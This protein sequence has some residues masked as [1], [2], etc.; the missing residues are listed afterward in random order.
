MILHLLRMC[1]NVNRNVFNDRKNISATPSLEKQ[2]VMVMTSTTPLTILTTMMMTIWPNGDGDS[3]LDEPFAFQH[4]APVVVREFDQ[5]TRQVVVAVFGVLSRGRRQQQKHQW[6]SA[7]KHFLSGSQKRLRVPSLVWRSALLLHLND[8]FLLILVFV[9][10]CRV[11]LIR[12][13]PL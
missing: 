8:L 2:S 4:I 5:S 13:F 3:Q 9:R 7:E 11:L 10:F 12:A 6:R 1:R